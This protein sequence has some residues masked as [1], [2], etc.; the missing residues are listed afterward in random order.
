MILSLSDSQA[1]EWR[2]IIPLHSTCKD[3]EKQ[4]KIKACSLSEVKYETRNEKVSIYISKELNERMFQRRC[5]VPIGTVLQVI[6]DY[7]NYPETR[8]FREDFSQFK[9]SFS[10]IETFYSS[11][12][13]GLEFVVQGNFVRTIWFSPTAKDTS[14]FCRE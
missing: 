14:A 4:L 13:K 2:N 8:E 9:E 3:V 10:D 1:G 5:D 6:V 12:E 7:K 11:K